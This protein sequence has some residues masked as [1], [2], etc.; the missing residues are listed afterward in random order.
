MLEESKCISR[1]KGPMRSYSGSLVIKNET[2]GE[3]KE[4]NVFGVP[5]MSIKFK[6]SV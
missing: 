2:I 3:S 6:K 5:K 1:S 4:F